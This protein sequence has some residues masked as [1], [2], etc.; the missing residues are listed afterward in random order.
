MDISNGLRRKSRDVAV[1]AV[2]ETPRVGSHNRRGKQRLRDDN[3]QSIAESLT[4][5]HMYVALVSVRRKVHRDRPFDEAERPREERTTAVGE[6]QEGPLPHPVDRQHGGFVRRI[7]QLDVDRGMDN[8][9][10]AD[11]YL[12]FFREVPLVPGKFHSFPE[13]PRPPATALTGKKSQAILEHPEHITE[14]L[15]SLSSTAL[16]ALFFAPSGGD[17]SVMNVR[18]RYCTHAPSRVMVELFWVL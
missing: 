17:I 5:S 13:L 1:T 2:D 12:F 4:R 7:A 16:L 14:A 15:P 18:F 9:A 10:V 6:K 3:S 8:E 11:L